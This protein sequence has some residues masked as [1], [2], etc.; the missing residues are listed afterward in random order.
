MVKDKS[1]FLKHP[2]LSSG[3]LVFVIIILFAMMPNN[4]DSTPKKN[5]E[6]RPTTTPSQ[7]NTKNSDYDDEYS[8]EVNGAYLSCMDWCKDIY[9]GTGTSLTKLCEGGKN[10]K[11]TD[12]YKICAINTAS[13]YCACKE[14]GGTESKCRQDFDE[15]LINIC[16]GK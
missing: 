15:G 4:N 1:W 3:I 7:E 9:D 14:D 8:F 12:N 5:Y 6:S 13:S 11:A 16:K 2:L 10:L